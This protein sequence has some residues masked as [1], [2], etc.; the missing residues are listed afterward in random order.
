MFIVFRFYLGII[1]FYL[2]KK[3]SGKKRQHLSPPKQNDL[4]MNASTLL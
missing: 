2:K 1:M 4:K 3:K